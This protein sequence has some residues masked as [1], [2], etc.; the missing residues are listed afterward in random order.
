MPSK[1]LHN[2][3]TYLNDN[4]NKKGEKFSKS[5][6]FEPKVLKQMAIFV[7]ITKKNPKDR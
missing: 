6:K 4:Y 3:L 1:M 5:L 2:I 7:I